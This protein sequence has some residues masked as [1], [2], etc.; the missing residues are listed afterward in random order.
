MGSLYI[1]PVPQENLSINRQKQQQESPPL[2]QHLQQQQQQRF[3]QANKS[4]TPRWMA[5]KPVN[6]EVPEWVRDDA[7]PP[8]SPVRHVNAPESPSNHQIATT[9]QSPVHHV[10]APQS[11]TNNTTNSTG[12]GLRLQINPKTAP[13]SKV[14]KKSIIFFFTP[15]I[16]VF[17]YKYRNELFQFKWS[18]HQHLHVL[19]DQSDLDHNLSIIINNQIMVHL[20]ILA[21][22]RII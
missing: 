5:Q 8:S 3:V 7:S 2:Q 17:L 4:P 1:P 11:F 13:N 20:L 21:V 18:R 12:T 22:V 19:L 9:P 6:K 10:Q 16:T 15:F 14:L